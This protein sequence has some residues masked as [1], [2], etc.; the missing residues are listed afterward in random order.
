MAEGE[1]RRASMQR[2]VTDRRPEEDD[3]ED[4]KQ[5]W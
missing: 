1:V 5:Y 3:Q 4:P 2:H